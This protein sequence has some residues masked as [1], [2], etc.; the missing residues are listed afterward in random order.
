MEPD[1]EEGA[2]R[3]TGFRGAAC[4]L[5]QEQGRSPLPPPRE[6]EGVLGLQGGGG[7][8]GDAASVG[9]SFPICHHLGLS[10]SPRDSFCSRVSIPT[11]QDGES[12]AGWGFRLPLR[13]MLGLLTHRDVAEW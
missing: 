1:P 6:R 4:F 9:L 10:H 2:V 7:P 8:A 3:G 11:R 13:G 12:G 5:R